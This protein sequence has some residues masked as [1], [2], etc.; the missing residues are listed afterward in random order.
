MQTIQATVNVRLLSKADRLFTGTL[1]GR[2]IEILQNAR[3]AGATKVEITNQDGYITVRDNG[4]GIEEFAKL[5]DL[6]GSGWEQEYEASEDPAGVGLFCLA[7]REVTIR[8]NGRMVT[9]K[10][11]GWTGEPIEI[12]DDPKPVRG[13]LLQFKDEPWNSDVVNPQAVFTGLKV[14][15]DGQDCPQ[16]PFITD[17]ATAY[18]ELGCKIEVCE[19]SNLNEWY[20]AHRRGL[21][22]S[23]NVFVNF[24]GQVV[25][26]DYHP[27]SEHHLYFLVD[28]TG[29]PTGIRLMLPARTQLVQN[30]AFEQ[31][32]AAMERE[33]YRYLQKRGQHRLPYKEYL[34]AKELGITLPEATPTYKVGLLTGDTPEPIEV[35]MPKEFPLAKC[36]RLAPDIEG[37][38]TDEAN[39]HLLAA[40]GKFKEPFVPVSINPQYD[41]YSWAKL[42]TVGKVQVTSGKILLEEAVWKGCLVCTDS[43]TI[44][45][46]TSDGKKWASSVC[47]AIQPARAEKQNI[48]WDEDVLLTPQARDRLSDMDILYHLGGFSDEGDTYDTQEYEFSEAM[49]RFWAQLVGPDEQFRRTIIKALSGWGSEWKSVTILPNGKVIMALK[50]GSKKTMKPPK[51]APSTAQAQ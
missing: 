14:M 32:K 30:Q 6:G 1:K 16:L 36:Y 48:W 39:V 34:R 23:D 20:R 44:S 2:I 33:A 38:E 46:H 31:L 24:H 10:E 18:P 40:I 51:P 17:E 22:Y 26:T 5:L 3:R 7:P 13:T 25:S 42:P 43:L 12:L 35:T 29:E 37:E 19:S 50:D 27:V 21:G 8:S 28:L 11:N 49:E 4:N 9:I 41:G 45:A 47:M 15:V